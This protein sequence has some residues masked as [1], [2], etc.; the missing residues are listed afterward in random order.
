MSSTPPVTHPPVSTAPP[1]PPRMPRRR[2]WAGPIVLIVIG[3]V[4]LLK[5]LGYGFPLF[6]TF[7]KWWP[8]LLIV[9]GLVKIF[10]YAQAKREGYAAAGIG[11]GGVVLL[12]FVILFGLTATGIQKAREH[13]KQNGPPGF[14]LEDD[15]L[16]QMF[17][18]RYQFTD[19]VDQA[20]PANATV[21][22]NNDRGDVRILV[23]NDDKLHITVRKTIF[24]GTQDEANKINANSKPTVTASE[25]A[26]AVAF[27]GQ[28]NVRADLD[29]LLPRKAAVE[30]TSGKGDV[31]VTGRDG[32]L[33]LQADNGD[34]SADDVKGNLT[35]HDRHGDLRASRVTG[36]VTAD[37][38]L[39]DVT[40]SD[41]TGTVS[42]NGEFFGD[43]QVSKIA[44]P[45]TFHSS[46]TDLSVAK[47]D[48]SLH[49]SGDSL[50]ASNVLGP[51]RLTTRSKDIKVDQLAGDIHVEN[52]N[53]NV[54]ITPSKLGNLEVQNRNSDVIVHLPSGAK[55]QMDA[56]VRNGDLNND[57]SELKVDKSGDT[58]HLTGAVGSGGPRVEISNEHA[59]VSIRKGA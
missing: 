22:V 20:L 4:F 30:V 52:T 25:T 33:V 26:V 1:P 29:I 40:I 32:D 21:T 11:G 57:F 59:D 56:T 34:V 36:N 35:V 18:S 13:W 10:E 38:R 5:N 58:T 42:L 43:T 8:A 31:S 54:E 14:V 53:G 6:E 37:G 27:T 50:E 12:I 3:V 24:A 44:G 48:G 17:G 23:G 9:W 41:V 28:G 55:F 7:A 49:L 47:V 51:F 2:S 16:A 46:R 45:F 39:N 15:D 19:Q